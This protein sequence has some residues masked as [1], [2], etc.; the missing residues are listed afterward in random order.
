[1]ETESARAATSRFCCSSMADSFCEAMRASET[2]R[3]RCQ[4]KA[5]EEICVRDADSRG[6]ASEILFRL[7]DIGP[8]LQQLRRDSCG[9]GW[10]RVHLFARNGSF[11]RTRVSPDQ[12]A[13][14]ILL[15][16]DLPF[17]I[18]ECS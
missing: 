1:M 4:S 5:W 9:N 14:L 8:P 11:H 2:S 10:W 7:A 6:C 15:L 17:N 13:D 12:N 3:K 16:R 18:V